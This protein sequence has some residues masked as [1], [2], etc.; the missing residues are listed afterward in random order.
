LSTGQLLSI[1][2]QHLGT[3]FR[4]RIFETNLQNKHVLAFLI[5]ID[6]EYCI[7]YLTSV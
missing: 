4:F 5:L 7:V 6:Q 2:L 3:E 1:E